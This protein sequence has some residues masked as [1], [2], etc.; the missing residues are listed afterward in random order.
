MTHKNEI[1][2]NLKKKNP[3][4]AAIL[5]LVIIGAGSMYANQIAKGVFQLVC[6][7]IVTVFTF[8]LLLPVFWISSPIIAYSDAVKHNT[9]LKVELDI[10]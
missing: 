6:C 1:L 7:F 9:L 5:S 8:G 2:Y 10:E 3:W 4:V